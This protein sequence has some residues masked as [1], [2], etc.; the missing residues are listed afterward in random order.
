MYQIRWNGQ[1][2]I[3]TAD[4]KVLPHR[5]RFWLLL[6]RGFLH[7][8]EFYAGQTAKAWI[9]PGYIPVAKAAAIPAES[10]VPRQTVYASRNV[11]AKS[12]F[13]FMI[14]SFSF[15]AIIII[16]LYTVCVKIN[17]AYTKLFSYSL[18]IIGRA[19]LRFGLLW[20][21]RNLAF[22]T[23]I[24]LSCFEFL[25]RKILKHERAGVQDFLMLCCN[26]PSVKFRQS[27]FKALSL[28]AQI[29]MLWRISQ[30]PFYWANNQ[31]LVKLVKSRRNPANAGLRLLW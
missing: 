13:N 27:D 20:C 24:T 29:K 10:Q 21:Y 12:I 30:A 15:H 11:Y 22:L 25:F 7:Q 18:T 17:S 14:D 8:S 26:D 19:V 5:M 2:W 3:W 23:K 28:L 4:W 31:N 16:A 1:Y 6:K 9:L